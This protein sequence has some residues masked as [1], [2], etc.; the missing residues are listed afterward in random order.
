MVV[1]F[2]QTKYRNLEQLFKSDTKESLGKLLN[3]FDTGIEEVRTEKRPIEE[4]LTFLPEDIKNDI[5]NDIQKAFDEDC[6]KTTSSITVTI[7]GKDLA[8]KNK[9][10]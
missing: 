5:M 9:R 7:V 10:R 6:E 3:Y 2:P 8:L 1:I 4:V